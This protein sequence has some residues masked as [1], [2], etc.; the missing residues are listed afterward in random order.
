M[1]PGAIEEGAKV[2]VSTVDALKQ[3][4][5]VLALVIFNILFMSLSVYVSLQ[6]SARWSDEIDRWEKLVQACLAKPS[7]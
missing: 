1:N 7:P 2:A 3:T 4:P 5:I 6:A